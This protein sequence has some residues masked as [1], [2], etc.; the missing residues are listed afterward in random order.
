[1]ETAVHADQALERMKASADTPGYASMRSGTA[2][3][4]EK[5]LNNA[6][7]LSL[8]LGKFIQSVG[9]QSVEDL[10]NDLAITNTMREAN[11]KDMLKKSEEFAEQQRKAEEASKATG[12]LGKIIGGIAT[13]VG[14]VGMVFGGAGA[15]LMAV[16]I[17]LMVLDPIMEAITGKSLTGMVLDPV[18]EHVFMPLMD[19]MSK[20]LDKIIDYT[21][22]GLLLKELDKLTGLDITDMVK[23]LAAAAATV[24][25]FIAVAYV[26]KSAAKTMID[27]MPK[28]LTEALNK[29]VK[30]TVEQV[31]KAVPDMVKNGSKKI[32]QKVGSL[33]KAVFKNDPLSQ[34][35]WLNRLELT[36][37]TAMVTGSTTQATGN[38]I[39]G[40][41]QKEAMDALA[42]FTLSAADMEILKQLAEMIYQSFERKQE[43]VQ[44][45]WGEMRNQLLQQSGTGRTI[46]RNLSASA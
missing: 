14:A 17:G 9:D 2:Q 33:Q 15:G 28:I 40:Q 4:T 39:S 44:Q 38:M 42:G 7:T 21:P 12:C 46:M 30:D 5:H 27:K 45:L 22:I 41:L 24:A 1:M 11:Q 23:A 35:K 43:L 6:A 8:L 29:A 3:Q 20:L 25:V 37:N 19:L 36:R 10:K 32:S 18:M 16:G 26:A 31:S 34:E 13:A